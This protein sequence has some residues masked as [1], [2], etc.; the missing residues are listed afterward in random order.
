[1]KVPFDI[2]FR[3]Q[4]E[5]GEVKVV[6]RDD[7]PVRIIC[8]DGPS[9]EMPI[10]GFIEG[11][12]EPDTF[13]S[14]GNY[15]YDEYGE[16]DADLFVIL[17]LPDNIF[18]QAVDTFGADHQIGMLHEEV[19]ELL[20]AINQYARGRVEKDAVVTEI[21]DV[22]IMCEQMAEIFGRE[23]TEAEKRRKIERL[24]GEIEK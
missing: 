4:I 12:I 2:K 6:T 10:A 24:A 3:P 21:A 8:W 11:R 1:M 7:R 15:R 14:S 9:F 23:E 5:S 20:A 19:G 16:S 13:S 18:K 17:P 22:M